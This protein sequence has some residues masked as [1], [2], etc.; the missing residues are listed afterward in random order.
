MV[1]IIQVALVNIIKTKSTIEQ[2][3]EIPAEVQSITKEKKNIMT[4]R[5]KEISECTQRLNN[6]EIMGNLQTP[7]VNP[8]LFTLRKVVEATT[9][10]V[11]VVIA[12]K[13][14]GMMTTRANRV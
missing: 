5:R 1:E 7:V 3:V 12:T 4:P 2:T 9:L 13:M 11:S 6:V 14:K 8:D 10:E